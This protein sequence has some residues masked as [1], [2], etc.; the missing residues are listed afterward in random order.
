MPNKVDHCK[1]FLP[2]DAL[3]GF[4]E[5]IELINNN[6]DLIN[7]K[8]LDFDYLDILNNKV[9][10][11]KK[12]DLIMIKYYLNNE[13]IEVIDHYKKIDNINKII[14]LNNNKINLEDILDI[15]IIK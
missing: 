4:K 1:Q 8:D 11:I 13:Y 12:N 5:A 3:T 6:I 9:S 7:K 14:I 10:N 2:F 15:E